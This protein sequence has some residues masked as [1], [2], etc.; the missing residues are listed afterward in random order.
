[1]PPIRDVIC[2]TGAG[3]TP[4]SCR[5]DRS[6]PVDTC[7][8]KGLKGNELTSWI[9][10][11]LTASRMVPPKMTISVSDGSRASAQLQ[12]DPGWLEK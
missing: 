10:P 8:L 3:E 11:I 9:N 2:S 4:M 6:F 1:M 12:R 5:L 7:T